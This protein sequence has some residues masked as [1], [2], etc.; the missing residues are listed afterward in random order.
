MLA[1]GVASSSILEFDRRDVGSGDR[2]FEDVSGPKP[3]LNAGLSHPAM[4]R[5]TL[6]A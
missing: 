3:T 5:E 1:S 6:L 2:L 4:L